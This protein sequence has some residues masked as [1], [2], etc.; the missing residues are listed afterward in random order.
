MGKP[1]E[2]PGN[3]GGLEGRES[4]GCPLPGF[5]SPL[6]Q[7]EGFSGPNWSGRFSLH[8]PYQT[9]GH[10]CQASYPG[11]ERGAPTEELKWELHVQGSSLDWSPLVGLTL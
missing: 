9:C 2:H 8:Q 10:I 6:Y 5:S 3:D 11:G 7:W 4:M 1:G